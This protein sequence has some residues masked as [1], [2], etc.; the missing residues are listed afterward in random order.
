VAP[1]RIGRAA[2][3]SRCRPEVRFGQAVPTGSLGTAPPLTSCGPDGSGCAWPERPIPTAATADSSQDTPAIATRA[4]R[5]ARANCR[6]ACESRSKRSPRSPDARPETAS[7]QGPGLAKL[8]PEPRSNCY[9]RKGAAVLC[10]VG[11]LSSASTRSGHRHGAVLSSRA[12][13]LTRKRSEC[14]LGGH[15]CPVRQ[16]GRVDAELRELPRTLKQ[17]RPAT[18]SST[19]RSTSR[20][21]SVASSFATRTV[22]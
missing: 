14:P 2:H 18:R 11:G 17:S 3:R 13:R 8:S 21:A 12:R 7:E 4:Q 6:S 19:V 9:S 22:S 16:D 10:T 1:F 5:S 15:H 20:G